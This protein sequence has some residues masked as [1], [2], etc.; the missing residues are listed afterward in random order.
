MA[1]AAAVSPAFENQP[2]AQ[3]NQPDQGRSRQQPQQ[4]TGEPEPAA[5]CGGY[6]QAER[7]KCKGALARLLHFPEMEMTNV[8]LLSILL[9]VAGLTVGVFALALTLKR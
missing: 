9:S 3:G 5:T 6:R 2:A 8:E 7:W 1:P 4:G